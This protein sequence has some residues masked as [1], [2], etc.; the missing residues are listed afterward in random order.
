MC[1]PGEASGEGARWLEMTERAPGEGQGPELQLT[2]LGTR[3][4]SAV[5]ITGCRPALLSHPPIRRS[6]PGG[7][8]PSSIPRSCCVQSCGGW[9]QGDGLS[10]PGQMAH[11]SPMCLTREML[12]PRPCL[13][14]SVHSG[15]VVPSSVDPPGAPEVLALPA[16][17]AHEREPL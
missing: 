10:H 6:H 2:A 8:P 12:L 14:P 13:S 11:V 7:C 1:D 5:D 4:G 17:P 15:V 16:G 3:S 9:A